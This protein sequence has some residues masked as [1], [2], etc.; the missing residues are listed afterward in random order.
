M[1]ARAG[2][3]PPSSLPFASLRD[4]SSGSRAPTRPRLA[5]RATSIVQPIME[6]TM[7]DRALVIFTDQQEVSPTVYLHWDGSLVPQLLDKLEQL[8]ASR[9]GDCQYACA[10]FIG[11]CHLLNP[12]SNLSLGVFNT[13]LKH[14]HGRDWQGYWLDAG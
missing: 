3:R 2:A 5:A 1:R 13:N 4:R 12:E 14:Y 10:R 11:L 7:G 6:E 8:M 9:R